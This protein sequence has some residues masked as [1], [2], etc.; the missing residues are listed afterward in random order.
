MV[1]KWGTGLG[2][3]AK[4]AVGDTMSTHRDLTLTCPHPKEPWSLSQSLRGA[5]AETSPPGE[6]R[7]RPMT[8]RCP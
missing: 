4:D 1:V 8:G 6:T 2:T 7:R 3:Q 5:T